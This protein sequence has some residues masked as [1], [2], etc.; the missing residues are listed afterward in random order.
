MAHKYFFTFIL[1]ICLGYCSAQTIS[2]IVVDNANSE[3]IPFVNIGL[4]GKGIGTVSDIDGNYRLIIPALNNQDTIIF[5]CI[6]YESLAIKV[7][8]FMQRYGEKENKIILVKRNVE[9]QEVTIKP[10]KL[11]QKT[12]GNTTD[13]KNFMSGFASNDLG[14]EL[15]IPMRAGKGLSYIEDVNFNIAENSYDSVTFRVNIYSFKKGM[16]DT[17]VLKYPI[18]VT[19]KIKS[20]TLTVDLKPYNIVVE[21]NFLVSLEWLK[22]LG[23]GTLK[24]SSS[25]LGADCYIRKTSQDTWEKEA[26]G[27][28]FY[29]NAKHEKN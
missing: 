10:K 25:F 14:S 2:G 15:G 3:S 28:G 29:C 21:G 4:K 26:I 1:I 12:Y 5:S 23:E 13:S 24:F 11:T 8:D 20:G 7:N 16:P 27:I 22:D 19:T 9:L 6:G 17:T 18:Y